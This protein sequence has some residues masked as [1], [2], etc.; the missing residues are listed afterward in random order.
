MW[1]GIIYKLGCMAYKRIFRDM[2][3]DKVKDSATT[4]DDMG[5]AVLDRIFNYKK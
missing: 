1:Y 4:L 2:I 3:K 5:L